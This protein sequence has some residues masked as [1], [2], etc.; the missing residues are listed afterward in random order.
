MQRRLEDVSHYF[1]GSVQTA[2]SSHPSADRPRTGERR[3]RVVHVLSVE[4]R[5]VGAMVVSGLAASVARLGGRVLVAALYEQGFDVAF[6]LGA[7]GLTG[8][9]SMAV[10]ASGVRVLPAPLVGSW[11]PGMLFVPDGTREWDTQVRGSDVVFLHVNPSQ[12]YAGTAHLA[13]PDEVVILGGTVSVDGLTRAYLAV[14]RAVLVNPGV[15]LALLTV[16]DSGACGARWGDLVHAVSTFLRRECVVIG[17]LTDTSRLCH[18]FFSGRFLDEAGEEVNRTLAPIATRWS[19]SGTRP[20]S[21]AP[22]TT[23]RF[24]DAP[25]RASGQDSS[26]ERVEG[27][28][29]REL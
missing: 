10:T 19:R 13:E 25:R 26:N 11:R 12:G 6:G 14:K 22:L 17:K 23:E 9:D 8:C 27:G 24:L 5:V 16:G 21:S 1:F 7:A 2:P 15:D 29:R 20:G 4:D 18:A 28:V 3:A